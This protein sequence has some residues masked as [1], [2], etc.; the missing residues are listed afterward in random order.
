MI[1]QILLLEKNFLT[2]VDMVEYELVFPEVPEPFTLPPDESAKINEMMTEY[3]LSIADF[4]GYS[5]KAH[6]LFITI[7]PYDLC[8][9]HPT[10]LATDSRLT[11]LKAEDFLIASWLEA[12]SQT[13]MVQVAAACY[14]TKESAAEMRKMII[15]RQEL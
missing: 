11:I 6:G 5:P 15:K 14:L 13:N 8:I 2:E 4:L 12:R 10:A 1:D 9:P 3:F 7:E